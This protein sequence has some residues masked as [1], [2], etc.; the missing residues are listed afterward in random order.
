M[1]YS[2]ERLD[3]LITLTLQPTSLKDKTITDIQIQEWI[4]QAAKEKENIRIFLMRRAFAIEK[5]KALELLIQQYQSSIIRLL[6]TVYKCLKNNKTVPLKNLYKPVLKILEDILGHIEHRYAKYFNLDEKV[7]DIYLHLSIQELRKQLK[8]FTNAL[9]AKT[10]DE[11]LQQYIMAP[12]ENFITRQTNI[13][14]SQLIYIKDVVEE[15][16]TVNEISGLRYSFLIQQLIYLN[17]NSSRFVNYLFELLMNELN[18]LTSIDS[19]MEL[20]LSY[21]RELNSLQIKP[22]FALKRDQASVKETMCWWIEEEIDQIKNKPQLS[23]LHVAPTIHD[24][25]LIAANGKIHFSISAPMLTLFIRAAIDTNLII[26]KK[27]TPVLKSATKF[28]RTIEQE[29]VSYKS[30]RNKFYDAESGS[31]ER[32]KSLLMDMYKAV[33]RY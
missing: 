30:L 7:P 17:F 23:L 21:S 25:D 20:L 16:S 31:K 10:T 18:Q 11:R 4:S 5:E 32:L 14:Y 27:K 28:I 13:T 3:L 15:I 26:N 24:E 9:L 22:G 2:L 8:G 33:H 12:V 29:T 19:K 6:D 1:K